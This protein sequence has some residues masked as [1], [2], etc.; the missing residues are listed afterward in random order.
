MTATF[1]EWRTRFRVLRQAGEGK[2]RFSLRDYWRYVRHAESP[3]PLSRF[4]DVDV[5]SREGHYVRLRIGDGVYFWPAEE[6]R[7]GLPWLYREVFAKASSNPH[8]YEHS[9]VKI[10]PGDHV[11][12]AGACEGFFIRYALEHG[13][14]VTAVEPVPRLAGALERT[15]SSEIERGLVQV[16]PCALSRQSG[17]VRIRQ[18]RDR[19]YES[20]RADTGETVRSISIDQMENSASFDFIK[21]DVEGEELAAV[22]GARATLKVRKPRLSIAV[23]HAHDTADRLVHLL[24]EIRPD[25]RVRHRG[26]FAY[27]ACTPRPFMVL[28]W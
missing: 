5:L 20:R 6:S 14:R 12:D 13:A 2:Y 16:L 22:Q 10:R 24:K 4:P 21:M 18:P 11:L 25:Y 3:G 27:Q 19:V 26:I 15:F 1:S 9:R 17:E 7:D 28:G 23:Y 8:A